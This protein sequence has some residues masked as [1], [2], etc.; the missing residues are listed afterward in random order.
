MVANQ[1]TERLR[2]YQDQL[3]EDYATSLSKK[4][5]IEDLD[6]A[7]FIAMY[8]Y[9]DAKI[10]RPVSAAVA[11]IQNRHVEGT[12]LVNDSFKGKEVRDPKTAA[13]NIIALTRTIGKD[14]DMVRRNL[15]FIEETVRKNEWP[16]QEYHMQ[17]NLMRKLMSL[18]SLKDLGEEG[19]KLGENLRGDILGHKRDNGAFRNR[20]KKFED[21]LYDRR[22]EREMTAYAV[23][24]LVRSFGFPI[25]DKI[26][27][28]V[29]YLMQDGWRLPEKEMRDANAI[30]LAMKHL[31]RKNGYEDLPNTIRAAV[32]KKIT[33]DLPRGR[34]VLH[35]YGQLKEFRDNL[36]NPYKRF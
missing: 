21:R 7:Q 5:F 31:N 30:Y 18:S 6:F 36:I 16:E 15:S 27:D 3:N 1:I 19:S 32:E 10:N 34:S 14:N 9:N 22:S 4:P 25:L 8:G 2:V 17:N 11:Y 12:E 24:I 35:S 29:E 26:K 23:A 28:S 13:Q 33:Q 20:A